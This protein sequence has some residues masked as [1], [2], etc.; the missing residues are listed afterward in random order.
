[1]SNHPIAQWIVVGVWTPE[2][3]Q[4][5]KTIDEVREI[6]QRKF[7]KGTF[8]YKIILQLE[9][10]Y[11]AT[12]YIIYHS[13]TRRLSER[14]VKFRIDLGI[15]CEFT[16]QQHTELDITRSKMQKDLEVDLKI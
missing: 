5:G 1:M 9:H 16:S 12:D 13:R 15:S 14:P 7:D 6:F 4:T 8:L 3:P 10:K 2:Q 11:L